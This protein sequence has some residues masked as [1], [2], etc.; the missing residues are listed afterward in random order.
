MKNILHSDYW[1][2]I[3]AGEFLIGISPEQEELIALR[4]NEQLGK[5]F[6]LYGK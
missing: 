4:M 5:D 6:S 3:P 2:E 1:V